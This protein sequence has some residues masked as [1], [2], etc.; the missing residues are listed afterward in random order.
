MQIGFSHVTQQYLVFRS[1]TEGQ[2][3]HRAFLHFTFLWGHSDEY[4]L[5]C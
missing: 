5:E 2:S 4:S 1:L 3:L